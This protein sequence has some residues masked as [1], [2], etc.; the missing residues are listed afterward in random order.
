MTVRRTESRIHM[1]LFGPCFGGT[2]NRAFAHYIGGETG[3]QG[4][5]HAEQNYVYMLVLYFYENERNNGGAFN[6]ED[7][8][9]ILHPVRHWYIF[10][11]ICLCFPL[12]GC[13]PAK[14]TSASGGWVQHQNPLGFTV[15]FPRGSRAETTEDNRVLV[16]LPEE[17]GFVV[18]QPFLMTAPQTSEEYLKAVPERFASLFPQA[19]IL[20]NAS[21]R[22][23]TALAEIEFVWKTRPAHAV[24][25]CSTDGATGMLYAIAAPTET[26]ALQRPLLGRV[27][28]SFTYT[29]SRLRTTEQAPSFTRWI[30]PNE[31]MFSVEAP[32]GWTLSG[33]FLRPNDYDTRTGLL[34][35][36]NDKTARIVI[37]DKDVPTYC[38][39][40]PQGEAFGLKE[41]QP[42]DIG[43]GTTFTLRRYLPGLDYAREYVQKHLA[44]AFPNVTFTQTRELPE[45]ATEL[46]KL[47][48]P[49]SR[50]MQRQRSV[51]VVEFEAT[52]Q[53][54]PWRGYCLA[55]TVQTQLAGTR[56]GIWTVEH[57]F[58]Y[59]AEAEQENET[60]RSLYRMVRSL[61]IEED[62]LARQIGMNPKFGAEYQKTNQA[63]AT[64]LQSQLRALKQVES[65]SNM[66]F[67][68][69]EYADPTAGTFQRAKTGNV[70]WQR[71][72]APPRSLILTELATW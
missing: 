46:E 35:Q 39:L 13:V 33:G 21:P 18:V 56:G 36:K 23:D 9:A 51:G 25:L 41:G 59:I 62:W 70:Y 38:L 68:M 54:K 32:D 42:F 19:R 72:G 64:A 3:C 48:P 52:V 58:G 37:G 45:L 47:A 24:L 26:F 12:V 40:T 65:A 71:M 2:R 49:V 30:E 69:T 14:E 53:G 16:S 67:G 28:A 1:D 6:R 17:G 29:E 15:V 4:Y 55:G 60:Q 20:R 57:L 66:T 10:I 5:I 11:V 8:S 34:A 63:I 44:A 7:T 50:G 31:G 22:A 27:A 43:I 61:R